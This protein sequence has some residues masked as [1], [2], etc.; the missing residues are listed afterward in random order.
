MILISILSRFSFP[1]MSLPV[2]AFLAYVYIRTGIIFL[3]SFSLE[4]K[5]PPPS[6]WDS[7]LGASIRRIILFFNP[8][9]GS[10]PGAIFWVH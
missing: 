6:A 9:S 8:W 3:K 10:R 4:K 2:F 1:A 7:S 5:K